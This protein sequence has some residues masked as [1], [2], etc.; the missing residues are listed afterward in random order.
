MRRKEPKQSRLKL[1]KE[2]VA[3]LKATG[4]RQTYRDTDCKGLLLRV[5]ATGKKSW[6]YDYYDP[7]GGRQTYT[8]ADADKV[9]PGE[10][11]KRVKKFG[12]DPAGEKRQRKAAEQQA[13]ARTLRT[14]L[15]GRYWTDDLAHAKSGKQTRRR[16]M[17]SWTPF[18]DC[19]MGTLDPDEILRHRAERQ[20]RGIRE[21]TLNRDRGVLLACLSKAE[22]WKLIPRNPLAVKSFGSVKAPEDNRVRWLGQRD[23]R[24]DIRDEHGVKIGERARLMKALAHPRT[25]LYVRQMVLLALNTGLR[26]GEIFKL[27]WENVSLAG[28]L[29]TVRAVSAK[30]NRTRHVPLNETARRVLLELDPVR[31]IS[32]FVF[33]NPDTGKP[34]TRI[35]NS[36]VNLRQLARLEDFRLHDCRHDFASRLV[37]AGVPLAEVRDLLGHSTIRLTERYAHVSPQRMQAAVRLLDAA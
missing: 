29:I 13:A 33:V 34:F 20:G 8:F 21:Q 22:T 31:H 7:K 15:F 11:R 14:F 16:I 37:Q 26:R 18:L 5:G 32:G 1:T 10:A 12:E 19:D 27:R 2:F 28:N 3:G 17:S 35:H 30:S 4:K 23:E 6:A 25:P 9:D 36:W 24:E